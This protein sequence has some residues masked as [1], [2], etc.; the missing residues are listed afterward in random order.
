MNQ[1]LQVAIQ[2]AEPALGQAR[3]LVVNSNETLQ[4]ALTLTKGLKGV[5]KQIV[6]TFKRMKQKADE[7][8]QEI[9]EQERWHLN[10]VREAMGI[11]DQKILTHNRELELA[12]QKERRE[13]EEA[14]RKSNEE[15]LL[16][17]AEHLSKQGFKEDAETVLSAPVAPVAVQEAPKPKMEGTYTRKF[18]SAECFN[19]D[20]LFKA[21]KDGMAS[22]GLLSVNDVALNKMA[23]ALGENFVLPGCRLI[24]KETLVKRS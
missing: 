19:F 7:A 3:A 14:A 10:P 21:V 15:R 9:L 12:R 24:V 5:E 2:Q 4:A 6:K 16:A 17:E 1:E 20:L 22:P 18:Y 13:A 23:S 11:V 8:K